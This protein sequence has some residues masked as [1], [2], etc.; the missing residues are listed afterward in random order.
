MR[1]SDSTTRVSR[2]L[3]P[4]GEEAAKQNGLTGSVES[5]YA[6]VSCRNAVN[7]AI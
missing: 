7:A 6:G 4:A 2:S 5:F 1:L 3:T